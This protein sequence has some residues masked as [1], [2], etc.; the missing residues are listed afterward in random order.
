MT[1][2]T[3]VL[4][5]GNYWNTHA[6]RHF[7]HAR[8]ALLFR[9]RKTLITSGML[10]PLSL[11]GKIGMFREDYFIDSVD[12]EFCLRARAVATAC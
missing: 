7:L 4:I 12:H 10:I 8:R 2:G 11:F 1:H 9:E 5:G 3:Q 6:Q